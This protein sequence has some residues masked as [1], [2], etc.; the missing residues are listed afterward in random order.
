MQI[1]SGNESLKWR[2]EGRM[3]IQ[4]TATTT[5]ITTN[6]NSDDNDHHNTTH[7]HHLYERHPKEKKRRGGPPHS[8]FHG[9]RLSPESAKARRN[10][11][12]AAPTKRQRRRLT[13]VYDTASTHETLSYSE[14]SSCFRLPE[15]SSRSRRDGQ[16]GRRVEV[17]KHKT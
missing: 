11:A 15:Q 5:T 6:N 10:S 2:G 12:N 3:R 14:V 8:T 13:E 1:T 4:S 16:R 7:T 17:T 9:P